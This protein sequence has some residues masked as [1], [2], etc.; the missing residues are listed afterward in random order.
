MYTSFSVL[1]KPVWWWPTA[2]KMSSQKKLFY[3][4][5]F[6]GYLSCFLSTLGCCA[7]G[8]KGYFSAMFRNKQEILLL[9]VCVCVCACVCVFFFLYW[10]T[11]CTREQNIIYTETKAKQSHHRPGQALRCPGGWGNQMSRQSAHEDFKDVVPTH[12]PSLPAWKYSWYSFLLYSESTS[13]P[14]CGRN[15]TR[16]PPVCIAVPQPI[17][18]PRGQI[19]SE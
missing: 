10:W 6:D 4:V 14:W 5:V 11:F 18:P 1:C 13:G 12:W 8:R 17:A 2:F 16:D 7:R 19:Y 15:W 3:K 9:C